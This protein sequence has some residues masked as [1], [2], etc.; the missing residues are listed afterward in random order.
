MR[1]RG[2]EHD[3]GSESEESGGERRTTEDPALRA[4]RT[5]WVQVVAHKTGTHESW[6]LSAAD[7]LEGRGQDPPEEMEQGHRHGYVVNG[8]PDISGA[9]RGGTGGG[10]RPRGGKRRAH[11][12]TWPGDRP[13]DSS[14]LGFLETTT[15]TDVY[16][17]GN[18]DKLGGRRFLHVGIHGQSSRPIGTIGTTTP[19]SLQDWAGG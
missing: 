2:E 10:D 14:G 1:V 12:A 19:S 11:F 18:A 13:A 5:R 15:H 9:V 4:V 6:E 17:E 3:G 8:R 7:R 16:A